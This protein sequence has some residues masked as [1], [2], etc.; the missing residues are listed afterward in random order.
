MDAVPVALPDRFDPDASFGRFSRSGDDLLERWDGRTLARCVRV[1]A[2]VVPFAAEVDRARLLVRARTSRERAIAARA[3]AVMLEPQPPAWADLLARDRA[4]A[5]VAARHPGL[6]AV[7]TLD[8]FV[9]LLHSIS[10]QQVN[11]RWATTTRRRLAERYG[12]ERSVGGVTVRVLDPTRLAGADVVELRALQLT[13]A[14]ARAVV[15]LAVAVVDGSLDLPGLAHAADDD[16]VR[17]LI[18]LPGIGPWTAHWY[19]ARVLGRPVVVTTDL[20]VRKA[21][22][23]LYDAAAIP[24]PPETAALTA[25]WG[26]AAVTAQQLVLTALADGTL[27]A[28]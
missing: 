27:S 28:R 18:R 16:V 5:A 15:A 4:L 1:G 25:H 9:A 11:L 23:L 10:A 13:T 8:P 12:A 24:S 7:R 22:G 3:A 14:K 6:H 2:E 17:E 19:L 26:S 20:A 21:V